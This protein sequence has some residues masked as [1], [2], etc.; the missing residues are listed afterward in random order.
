MDD[1]DLRV[2]VDTGIPRSEHALSL[3]STVVK[4]KGPN[5][6]QAVLQTIH[7]ALGEKD[8]RTS[9]I[10]VNGLHQSGSNSDSFC[11]LFYN[12]ISLYPTVVKAKRLDKPV[13]NKVQP[14]LVTLASSETPRTINTSTS[15]KS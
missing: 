9:S 5:L 4:K 2:T 3:V 15:Q 7:S 14:L 10:I 12:E 8:K 6:Q 11:N 1:N 13:T